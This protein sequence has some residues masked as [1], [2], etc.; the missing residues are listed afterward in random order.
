[1]KINRFLFFQGEKKKEDSINSEQRK[2]KVGPTRYRF[3]DKLVHF[4]WPGKVT[5][6]RVSEADKIQ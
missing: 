3:L 5:R 6:Y 4:E 1:M 2:P